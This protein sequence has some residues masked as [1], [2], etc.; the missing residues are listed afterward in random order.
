MFGWLQYFVKTQLES[1]EMTIYFRRPK[2][3][4]MVPTE[5]QGK[6]GTA[7]NRH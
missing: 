6:A 5:G 3:L 4:N 1:S 2:I 7:Q